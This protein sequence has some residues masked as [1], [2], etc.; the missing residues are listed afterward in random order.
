[1]QEVPA[2]AAEEVEDL[3]VGH[4]LVPVLSDEALAQALALPEG[5]EVDEVAPEAADQAAAQEQ[6][7][8]GH[9]CEQLEQD[10]LRQLVDVPHR[11]SSPVGVDKLHCRPGLLPKPGSRSTLWWR[12]SSQLCH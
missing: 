6:L 8:G 9:V 12:F 4:G 10:I 2:E 11:H 7:A 5:H 3:P 1:M